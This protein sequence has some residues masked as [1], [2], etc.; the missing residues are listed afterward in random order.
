MPDGREIQ[1]KFD[2]MKRLFGSSPLNP[3]ITQTFKEIN[4]L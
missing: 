2:A 1:S 3:A 4:D